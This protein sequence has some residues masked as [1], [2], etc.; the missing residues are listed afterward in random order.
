MSY[1]HEDP[2]LPE[3]RWKFPAIYLDNV[4]PWND[5]LI[6]TTSNHF[7]VVMEADKPA[8]F[9]IER[10]DPANG[11]VAGAYLNRHSWQATSVNYNRV[12]INTASV[13]RRFEDH[14][15]AKLFQQEVEAT[16]L[17]LH[18]PVVE[19]EQAFRE[20]KRAYLEVLASAVEGMK[21]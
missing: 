6:H 19:A 10:E 14:E 1:L 5:S 9:R 4:M 7:A 11:K 8:I 12:R 17:E 3:W 2:A 13:I 21:A 18:K 15:E 20:A 16:L